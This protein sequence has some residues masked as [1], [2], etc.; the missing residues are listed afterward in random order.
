MILDAYTEEIKGWSV[1]DT[2]S[3]VYLLAALD[4]ALAGLDSKSGG[5]TLTHHSDRGVQYASREYVGALRKAGI[6]ISMTENGNPK[7]NAQTE[8]INGTIKNEL[9][10]EMSFG[11]IGEVRD[12]VESAVRF[13][14]NERP[15][16]SINMLT[17]ARHRPCPVRYPSVVGV[18]P[19][20]KIEVQRHGLPVPPSPLR[21]ENGTGRRMALGGIKS[22]KQYKKTKGG[23]ASPEWIN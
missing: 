17:P 6:A 18:T 19:T 9:L 14:N 11:S 12:A 3:T 7:D 8:R 20:V 23:V 2:L 21:V 5:R 10:K 15:H 22:H 13:Y 1:G 16:M 4:M